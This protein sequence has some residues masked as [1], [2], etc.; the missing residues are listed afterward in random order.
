MYYDIIEQVII[1][2]FKIITEQLEIE[3]CYA[4]HHKMYHTHREKKC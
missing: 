4:Q 2:A 3:M 1:I